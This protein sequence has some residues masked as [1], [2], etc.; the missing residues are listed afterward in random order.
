MGF[1]PNTWGRQAWHFIHMVALSYPPEE[2]LTDEIKEKY[3]KFFESL[4]YALPC[5]YCS[6]HFREKFQKNPP[7]LNNREELFRWTVDIHNSVNRDN[8]KR[9][10][11][12]EEAKRQIKM[13][14]EKS[15]EYSNYMVTG[16]AVSVSLITMICL[17]GYSMR[18]G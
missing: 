3:Y 17:F 5:P 10:I 16:V 15:K 6:Q 2:V 14:A 1:N 7:P 11:S 8:G 12:Y 13:N 9:E 4:G 18:R